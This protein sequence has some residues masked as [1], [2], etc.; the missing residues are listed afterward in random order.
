MKDFSND[1]L[2]RHKYKRQRTKWG[3]CGYDATDI[4]CW[5]LNVMPRMIEYLKNNHI[6]F[7][8]WILE[9]YYEQNKGFKEKLHERII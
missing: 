3:F 8:T 6:G 5:F 7:P 4:D 2:T 9:E 1:I